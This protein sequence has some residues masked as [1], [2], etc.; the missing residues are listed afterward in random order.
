MIT[1]EKNSERLID[2][3]KFTEP[4]IH[5]LKTLGV[6]A[7][8]EGKNNLVVNGKKISGNSAHVM[9]NRIL[10]HGTLLFNTNLENLENSILPPKANISDKA[11][12]SIRATVTNISEE[13][14]NNIPVDEFRKRFQQYLKGYFQVKQVYTLSG[15]EKQEIE[16]LAN[17][18]Y[19]K[20][21]WNY[22]YSPA[23]E[24]S[25]KI[26]INEQHIS[27]S[28]QVK[29]G[30]ISSVSVSFSGN[31]KLSYELSAILLGTRHSKE[32]VKTKLKEINHI[33]E[34]YNLDLNEIIKLF[35]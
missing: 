7:T 31:E 17:N 19:R 4:V 20:W 29:N 8:F 10:H 16:I 27:A 13:L 1:T 23:Y 32:T 25:N 30:L 24:V 35:F 21:E 28:I 15:N 2:F 6:E 5:F 12:K 22:G 3:K 14:N 11:V 9:K 34:K 26:E 18:K 33:F